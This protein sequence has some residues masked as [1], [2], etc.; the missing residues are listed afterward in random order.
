MWNISCY[1][2]VRSFSTKLVFFRSKKH[3]TQPPLLCLL[4]KKRRFS[5]MKKT[6]LATLIISIFFAFTC[7]ASAT[8]SGGQAAAKSTPAPTDTV[9]LSNDT[10]MPAAG[11]GVGLVFKR[12][13]SSQAKAQV[14]ANRA[15]ASYITS[16][17]TLQKKSSGSYKK[18]TS[19]S[20]TV[21]NEQIN[22]IKY[23]SIA[24]SGTYRIKVT[25]KYKEGSLIRSNTYYKSMS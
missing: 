5:N 17:I 23:F 20:K 8:T 14:Q 15:G 10:V 22:H 1:R 16:T 4:V 19:A 25:V 6:I 7:T 21:Y 2:N 9:S 18:V 24:S 13:S 11:S 12:T 3:L